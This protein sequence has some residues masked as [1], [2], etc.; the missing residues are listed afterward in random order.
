MKHIRILICLLT[1]LSFIGHARAQGAG[2]TYQGHL[3]QGGN[4]ANGLFP[5]RPSLSAMASLRSCSTS[6]AV[7]SWGRRGGCKSR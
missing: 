2:F 4:S 7:R 3:T 5:L 6:A 1:L